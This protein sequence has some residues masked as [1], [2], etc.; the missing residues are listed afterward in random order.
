MVSQRLQCTVM[1]DSGDWDEALRMPR[2]DVETDWWGNR[3]SRPFRYAL[4]RDATHVVLVSDVPRSAPLPLGHKH[5][6]FVENL[7]EPGTR[8]DTAE[9][10]IML[11]HGRYFEVHVSPEGA[12]WYM[13]FSA[14]RTPNP[15]HRPSG[16]ETKV[17][18]YA[19]SWLGAI[20][21]PLDQLP[22]TPGSLVRFQAT[23][24]LC[25]GS[26]PVYIT[27]AGIPDFE[28]D[29]HS[30]RVFSELML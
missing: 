6:A 13:E 17:V 19:D 7:A 5:G 2:T 14:Y 4:G 16:V 15:G 28:P 24:A 25:S 20:R 12:W 18:K 8:T 30:D 1:A 29:F 27:S 3:L 9:F 10:F 26:T 11:K 22:I 23:L 21:I